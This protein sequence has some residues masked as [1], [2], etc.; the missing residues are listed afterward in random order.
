MNEKAAKTRFAQM[1]ISSPFIQALPELLTTQR[2]SNYSSS[3]LGSP[4]AAPKTKSGFNLVPSALAAKQTLTM[5]F[6]CPVVFNQ[7]DFTPCLWILVL[8]TMSFE[9]GV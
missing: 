3:D 9:T 8:D 1:V 4:L 2:D 6:S 7:T 5:H